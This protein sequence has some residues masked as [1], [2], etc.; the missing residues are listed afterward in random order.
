MCP[1]AS[2]SSL[3][4]SHSSSIR[5]PSSANTP[6]CRSTELMNSWL[7]SIIRSISPTLVATFLGD[8]LQRGVEHG[9][10]VRITVDDGHGRRHRPVASPDY[11]ALLKS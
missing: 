10:L 2:I 9:P 7:R 6:F 1:P 5:S 11:L 8:V 4:R 3:L